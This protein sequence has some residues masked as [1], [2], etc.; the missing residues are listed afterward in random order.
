MRRHIKYQT[1][2][3]YREFLVFIS[4][5]PLG[6]LLD[7][8]I[9][10]TIIY[11]KESFIYIILPIIIASMYDIILLNQWNWSANEYEFLN[12]YVSEWRIILIVKNLIT[13]IYISFVLTISWYLFWKLSYIDKMQF[14]Q[15][16]S[17]LWIVPL[18]MFAGNIASSKKSSNVKEFHRSGYISLTILKMILITIHFIF[19]TSFIATIILFCLAI[20]I[21]WVS[22]FYCAQLRAKLIL[23][24]LM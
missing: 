13:M 20:L 10:N 17:M 5:I 11:H 8:Y 9:I 4:I 18:L 19:F 1:I 21:W 3:F 6:I 14:F 15:S 12:I 2:L 24:E 22:S 7:G 16:I 23:K